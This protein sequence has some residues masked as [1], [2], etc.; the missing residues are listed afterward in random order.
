[1]NRLTREKKSTNLIFCLDLNTKQFPFL[2]LPAAVQEGQQRLQIPNLTVKAGLNETRK[3]DL[4]VTILQILRIQVFNNKCSFK[5]P[6]V[7]QIN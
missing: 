1:M 4:V 3:E 5:E 7:E 6:S 2:P